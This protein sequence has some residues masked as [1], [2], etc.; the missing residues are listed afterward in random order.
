MN[1]SL[2]A[3]VEIATEHMSDSDL[4][5]LNLCAQMGTD[6]RNRVFDFQQ[7]EYLF[8]E[9]RNGIPCMHEEMRRA[10]ASVLLQRLTQPR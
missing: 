7:V 2:A 4:A 1:A 9:T 10:L 5:A 3:M 6:P 8:T